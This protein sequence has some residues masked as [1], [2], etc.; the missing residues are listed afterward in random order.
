[1]N[2]NQ[3]FKRYIWLIDT[4]YSAG[5][6]SLKE[7]QNRWKQSAVNDDGS[8][9]GE[10]T[11]HRYREAIFSIWG[12]KITFD[13]SNNTYRLAN[14]GDLSEGGVNNWLVDSIS[15]QNMIAQTKLL[16]DRVV[17]EQIPAGMRHMGPIVSSM[18]EGKQLYVSYKRFDADKPHSFY[19]QPYCLK[20]F[21]Q[22]W[23]VVGKPH[24]HPEEIGPRIYA[25]DRLQ[26]VELTDQQYTMP[27]TFSAESYFRD[28]FGID[29]QGKAE[30]IRIRVAAKEANYL[31]SLPL[32]HSQ[33]ECNVM[34]ETSDFTFQISPTLDFKQELRKLGSNCEI[35][36]P[37]WLRDEFYLEAIAIAEANKTKK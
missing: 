27:N 34:R 2:T 32:H 25:L 22:R 35:L 15:I 13:I 26:N 24:D 12:I 10:R 33:R 31:R 6:I 36:E 29:H 3:L 21:R 14:L 9:I 20:Q 1:M 17:F 23:Y 4:I 28:H 18:S 30:N 11:F 7:I 16:H 8:I 37:Q 5:K 19:L